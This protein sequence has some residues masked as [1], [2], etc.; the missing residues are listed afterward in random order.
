MT[1]ST[2][3]VWNPAAHFS[4]EVEHRANSSKALPLLSGPLILTARTAFVLWPPRLLDSVL[5][6][7]IP[8]PTYILRG[9]VDSGNGPD[10]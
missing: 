1:S 10:G 9:E 6:T 2:R 3:A 4:R 8:L 5:L 7:G